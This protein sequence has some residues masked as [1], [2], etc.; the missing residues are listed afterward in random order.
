[1]GSAV[2]VR[3][4]A[5]ENLPSE[6]HEHR[7]PRL[8]TLHHAA[9]GALSLTLMTIALLLGAAGARA[10]DNEIRIGNTIDYS[11]PVRAAVWSAE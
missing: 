5:L 7:S 6:V 2:D 9:T 10:A 11:G 4:H 1:M 8:T 3:W